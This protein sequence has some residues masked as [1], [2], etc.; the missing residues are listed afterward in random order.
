M[1]IQKNG[2]CMHMTCRKCNY[3]FCWICRQQVE[4]HSPKD[5]LGFLINYGLIIAFLALNYLNILGLLEYILAL[6][7]LFVSVILYHFT[8][9]STGV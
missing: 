6:I 4:G 8:I 3:Y 2:G 1:K 9:I 7:F 5:C